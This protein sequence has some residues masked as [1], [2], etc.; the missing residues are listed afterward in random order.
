MKKVSKTYQ[1]ISYVQ[2]DT[3]VMANGMKI[4][5]AFRGGTFEPPRNGTFTTNE[6]GIIEAMDK[7]EN[8]LGKSY[9]LLSVT[10]YD[11]QPVTKTAGLPSDAGEQY[12]IVP[13][14]NS[15]AKARE[16][17]IKASEDGNIKS[18]ITAS[19]LKNRTQVLAIAEDVRIRFIDLPKE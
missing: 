17:L 4:L 12:Q 5:I 14:I 3:Y 2:L 13:G 11:D 9:H 19:L 18:G 10:E 7:P 6:P 8:G 1:A 15:V 16:Y